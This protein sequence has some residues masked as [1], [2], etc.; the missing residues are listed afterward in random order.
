MV[1]NI[2]LHDISI[3]P[4]KALRGR[5]PLLGSAFRRSQPSNTQALTPP[6]IA[7]PPPRIPHPP[8]IPQPRRSRSLPCSLR[9]RPWISNS[10]CCRRRLAS[11]NPAPGR[12][13]PSLA[14][15]ASVPSPPLN[16]PPP[17]T[18]AWNHPTSTPVHL[19]PGTVGG[20]TP[21]LTRVHPHRLLLHLLRHRHH[22]LHQ[23]L[24][25]RPSLHT[26]TTS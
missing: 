11:A 3:L 9:A 15:T 23:R 7:P 25:P 21:I 5:L 4:I 19:G 10:E 2:V 22:R 13:A 17:R 6:R 16:P 12:H 8:R 18:R 26:A 24:R 20:S 14:S 1:Q